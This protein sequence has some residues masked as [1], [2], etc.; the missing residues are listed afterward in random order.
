[1]TK[2]PLIDFNNLN[3][4]LRNLDQRLGFNELTSVASRAVNEFNTIKQ[5]TLSTEINKTVAGFK[6]LTEET[7]GAASI[8]DRGVA[9]LVSDPPGLS[10]TKT[11]SA[12][13]ADLISMT[14][15][16]NVSGG[17]LDF[18]ITASTPEAISKA[19]VDVTNQPIEVVSRSISS[20]SNQSISQ[21]QSSLSNVVKDIPVGT[22]L[23]GQ[24]NK[25]TSNILQFYNTTLT[26]NIKNI[27]ETLNSGFDPVIREIIG[28]NQLPINLVE[29]VIQLVEQGNVSAA[30]DLL[31]PYSSLTVTQI[32]Q[33]LQT[34]PVTVSDQVTNSTALQK[35]TTPTKNVTYT[36]NTDFDLIASKQELDAI[37]QGAEREITEVVVHWTATYLDQFIQ[38]QDIDRVHKEKGLS[39][40]GYHF[41][42]LRDGTLQRGRPI[43]QI[44]SHAVNHNTYTIGLAFVGGI[45]LTSAQAA[46]LGGYEKVSSDSRYASINS[47]TSEQ[48]QTFHMFMKS[49]FQAYPYGQAF[50]HNDIEPRSKIDPGFDVVQYVKNSYQKNIIANPQ[51][52][53]LSKQELINLA[54]DVV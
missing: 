19:L 34:V 8:V 16:A 18:V 6:A 25:F 22:E 29:S 7:D 4:E 14:G 48:M 2:T 3:V 39:S 53:T 27:I 10:I 37:L 28:S 49:F 43:N 12:S 21:L 11:A 40:I 35:A 44:G 26:G 20:L 30:A 15:D 23:L 47:L 13:N 9:L 51:E 54:R 31:R 46:L 5:T 32:E 50:G 42:I 41:V 45:N 24:V 36:Q 38:A 1:M 17:F 52:P 33:L